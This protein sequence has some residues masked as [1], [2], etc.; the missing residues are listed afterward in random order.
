MIEKPNRT[1]PEAGSTFIVPL[2]VDPAEL[3]AILGRLPSDAQGRAL[4]AFCEEVRQHCDTAYN[5]QMQLF[6][7]RYELSETDRELLAC[8]G[9]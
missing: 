9:P 4:R 2:R 8:L 5:V 7:V 6:Y 3:G 1:P